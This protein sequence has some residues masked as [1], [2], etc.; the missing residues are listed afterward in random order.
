[1]GRRK[2][3]QASSSPGGTR[4]ASANL[5]LL[6][7]IPQGSWARTRTHAP[8]V[9]DGKAQTTLSWRLWC[10]VRSIGDAAPWRA[11]PTNCCASEAI[12]QRVTFGSSPG[13][14]TPITRG[15]FRV[16]TM[17]LPATSFTSAPVG[18]VYAVHGR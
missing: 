1:V 18:T 8:A 6:A 10:C 7:T 14:R 4:R 12:H 15:T 16:R 5:G 9:C 13:T 2:A 17:T 11:E 3:Q